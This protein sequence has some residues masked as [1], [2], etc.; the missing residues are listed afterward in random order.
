[1]KR[2]VH[3]LLIGLT[4]CLFLPQCSKKDGGTA[5]A[6]ANLTIAQ[7]ISTDSSGQVNF[8]A[9][10]D[11]A[12][13]YFFEFGDG[14]KASNTTGEISYIFPE[15]GTADYTVTVTAV[16]SS[17]ATIKK[18]VQIK[19]TKKLTL[20]WSQEFD[21][22]GAPDPAVWG[23]DIGGGGWGNN[24]LEYYTNN[25]QNVIVDGGLLKIKAIKES[26]SGASYSSA[27]ILTKD[28]FAF[29]YGKVE[30]RAKLPAGGGTWPAIWMLGSN[31]GSSPWPACGEIDIMEHVGNQLNRIYGTLHYP[32]RFGSNPNGSSTIISDATTAFHVYKLSWTPVSIK[33]YVDDFLFHTVANSDALPF[34]HDFFLIL[35]V[36]MGGNFGGA[37]DPNFTSA[38]MEV[39]YVRVYK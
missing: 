39:D 32:E 27:R 25:P 29:T 34:N 2:L 16:G 31:I 6:P 4:G 13:R 10:A 17:G 7:I 20:F 5:P 9:R 30:A 21:K 18:T 23:Y 11:N 36:A 35:N 1:M 14:G 8:T 12:I 37:V 28:K 38:A 33:I 19:V 22:D 3:L 15:E 26:L 24:E